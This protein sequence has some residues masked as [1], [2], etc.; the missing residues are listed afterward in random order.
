MSVATAAPAPHTVPPPGGETC[1]LCGAPLQAEQEWCLRC[2]AAART[3]LA[4]APNWRTPVAVIAVVCALSL[5]ILAAALVKLAGGSGAAPAAATTTVT[6][7]AAT[8]TTPAFTT[9]T[10]PL[11]SATSP[12]QGAGAAGGAGSLGT[13]STTPATGLPGASAVPGAATPS[14]GATPTT[15]AVT[16]RSLSPATERELRRLHL[17]PGERRSK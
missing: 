12:T 6:S 13:T 15:G 8:P 7:A 1:P 10:T 11:P 9:A 3:R 5:G 17:L 14:T 4:A 2:G 16:K